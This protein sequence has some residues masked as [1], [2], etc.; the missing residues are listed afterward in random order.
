M[1]EYYTAYND[2]YLQVHVKNL[3]WADDGSSS[4]VSEAMARL[5][6][7]KSA[8]ILELGCG[9]GRDAAYLLVQDFDLLAT[10]V[11]PEAIRYCRARFPRHSEHFEVLDCVA[12]SLGEKFDFIYAIAVIHMLVEDGDRA[13]FYGF[14]RSHLKPQDAALICSMGDGEITCR[15]DPKK[16]FSLQER[17]HGQTGQMLSV[18][19]TSCR[20]VSHEEFRWEIEAAGLRIREM[21][22]TKTV[23][24][25]SSMLYAFVEAN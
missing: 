21:G 20:M 23:P 10:D 8:Q 1:P 5:G 25:F 12:G 24:G 3:Q 17:E 11:S 6:F 2:R 4:I 18:A 9:E 16:A 13:R 7:G 14:L 15:S 22:L 19:A